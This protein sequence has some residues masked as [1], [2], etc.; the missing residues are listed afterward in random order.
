MAY[1]RDNYY[2][3]T[4]FSEH[5]AIDA[6]ESAFVAAGCDKFFEDYYYQEELRK[7]EEDS[8]Y[9]YHCQE[10]LC[11]DRGAKAQMAFE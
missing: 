11:E 1:L 7:C 4:I 9:Y 8:N 2:G 6:A 3:T 10:I 5:I